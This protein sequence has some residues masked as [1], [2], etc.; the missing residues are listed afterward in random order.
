MDEPTGGS[1][2]T[3]ERSISLTMDKIRL[4][5][6]KKHVFYIVYIELYLR[7]IFKLDLKNT[8]MMKKWF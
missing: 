7:M 5:D 4:S 2:F 3:N 8:K 6:K 1:L